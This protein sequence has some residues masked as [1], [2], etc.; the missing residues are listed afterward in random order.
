MLSHS[1]ALISRE[2][3]LTVAARLDAALLALATHRYDA[4]LLDLNLPDSE[5]L[6]TL[7]HVT[8]AAAQVPVVVLTGIDDSGQA[9]VAMRLGAQDWLTKVEPDPALVLRAIRYAVER[10]RLANGLLRSQKLEAVGRLAGN[11]AHEFNNVLMA[12]MANAEVAN[13]TTDP[14]ARSGALGQV[15]QAATRGSLITRQLLGLSRPAG[16][17]QPVA[18]VNQAI[19][20]VYELCQAVLPRSVQIRRM[21]NAVAHVALGQ[22]QLEQ[23]LLNL[24]LNARDAMPG[25]GTIAISVARPVSGQDGAAHSEPPHVNERSC[26]RIVVQDTGTGIH[27]ETMLHVFEPFFST[28]GTA[29]TG[30]GLMISKEIIEQ[31]GGTIHIESEFGV[32][33]TVSLDLPDAGGTPRTLE[34]ARPDENSPDVRPTRRA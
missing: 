3:E 1:L 10:K 4:V 24:I 30:L 15:K 20:T 9:Q 22:D 17:A 14:R 16:P 27:P 32:G 23:V 11:V 21:A 31:A 28:K 18:D 12:I 25:G 13:I 33:T 8:S 34:T 2:L 29:G 7:R 6:S 26:V 5:G 19:T